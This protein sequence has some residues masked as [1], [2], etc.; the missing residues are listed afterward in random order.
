M[1]PNI[2]RSV[3]FP[4]DINENYENYKKTW[5]QDI[6]S[7]SFTS[8]I[9]KGETFISKSSLDEASEIIMCYF[10]QYKVN[11]IKIL[12]PYAGNGCASKI[13]YDKLIINY[14]DI[15]IKS[16]DIQ[17]LTEYI[18][19]NSHPVE[20][21]INAYDTIE[22]YKNDDYNI[23]MMI[24]PPPYNQESSYCDYFTIKKWY[25]LE[26]SQYFIFIGELGASDGSEGLY[27]YLLHR[28]SNSKW[29]LEVRF[30]LK[31]GKDIYGGMIEKELFIFKKIM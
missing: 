1:G 31:S 10:L 27:N 3:S 11:K 15:I 28:D 4:E 17:D 18:D 26:S 12:E 22:K 21:N 13:I 20:F 24:S 7:N 29:S 5:T 25:E 8:Q 16:T 23:L 9:T 14:P 19:E 30:M 6:I 2:S